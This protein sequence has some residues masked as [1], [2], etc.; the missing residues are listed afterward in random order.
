MV[1]DKFS[2]VRSLS[3][4]GRT[5]TPGTDGSFSS[6]LALVEGANAIVIEAED[7]AGNRS[8]AVLT[9]RYVRTV[10]ILLVIGRTTM[11]VDGKAM[12]IDASGKVAPLIQ[13]GRTLL[14]AR[15][16][17][18][19]LGGTVGWDPVARKVT[20]GLN[21]HSVE[22]WIGQTTARVDGATVPVDAADKRVV[23]IITAGRTL[24]PLRFLS[25]S[26][27]LDIVW[28]AVLRSV[29]LNYAP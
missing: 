5:I 1:T 23:P 7:T 27:G 29:T 22:L 17:I 2:G 19:T 20:V 18:E 16:L 28:D 8:S 12:T 24:L 3:V 10:T 6:T 4:S 21:G 15:V 9:V 14:P 13:N 25:E 11:L 26:L